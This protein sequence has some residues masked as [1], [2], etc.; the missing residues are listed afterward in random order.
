MPNPNN[1]QMDIRFEQLTGKID[2]K[3]YDMRGVLVD[4]LQVYNDLNTF[5]LNYNMQNHS[6]GIYF[7]VATGKEGTVTRKVVVNP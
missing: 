6:N 7:F 3:V 4:N 2:L 1:G 5:V